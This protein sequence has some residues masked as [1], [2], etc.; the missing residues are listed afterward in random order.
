MTLAGKHGWALLALCLLAL[1]PIAWKQ[2]RPLRHD[3]CRTPGALLDVGA[4]P[5]A[6][7][8]GQRLDRVDDTVVQWS[9]G[10]IDRERSR[11]Q[12]EFQWVRSFDARGLYENPTLLLK[13]EIEP[14]EHVLA[15]REVDGTRLPVHVVRDGAQRPARMA[16]YLFV[17]G[18]EPVET[19]FLYALRSS[20]RQF[21]TG[22]LPLT[23]ILVEAP[24]RRRVDPRAEQKAVAWIEAAW[25]HHARSCLAAG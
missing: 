12:M 13:T 24:A 25:R 7:A 3:P 16:A 10:V 21:F 15:L 22:T 1:A 14:E 8:R 5:G 2:S 9:E 4:V 17:Y 6:T 20:A 19:P 11:A 18:N 23:A